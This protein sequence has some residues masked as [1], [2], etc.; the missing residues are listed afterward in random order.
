MFIA[1]AAAALF[2]KAAMLSYHG[3]LGEPRGLYAVTASPLDLQYL[4][5]FSWVRYGWH[6]TCKHRK[7]VGK[8]ADF[9]GL[10]SITFE[11][12]L[13]HGKCEDLTS[14]IVIQIYLTKKLLMSQQY[15]EA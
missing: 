3:R 14:S 2:R 8:E 4:S 10:Q 9:A 13:G 7:M 11:I 15:L 12:L 6:S 1:Q 5:S